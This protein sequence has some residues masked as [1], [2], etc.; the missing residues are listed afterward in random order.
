MKSS[1]EFDFSRENTIQITARW[2]NVFP[3][4]NWQKKLT[5]LME[6]VAKVSEVK[7]E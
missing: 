5:P 3:N 7:R 2:T 4:R 6:E 1:T